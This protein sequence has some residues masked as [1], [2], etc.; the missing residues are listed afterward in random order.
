MERKT[1]QG[2]RETIASVAVGMGSLL[3]LLIRT[4]RKPSR[5]AYP[6]QQAAMANATAWIGT[7]PLLAPWRAPAVL[8]RPG[9]L[10]M[11]MAWPKLAA[12]LAAALIIAGVTPL[13][14]GFLSE[15]TTRGTGQVLPLTLAGRQAPT[16]S[17]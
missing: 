5:A 6:C 15:T 12:F 1:A 10:W 2:F 4:G 11:G 17:Y 8:S 7:L 14:P 3:W 16:R 9:A 13:A